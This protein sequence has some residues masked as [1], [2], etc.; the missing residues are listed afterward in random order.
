MVI[1]GGAGTLAGP[2]VGTSVLFPAT[3]LLQGFGQW[4]TF[5][6]GACWRRCCS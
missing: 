1:L 3:Q 6:Y 4:Q 2:L 5:A